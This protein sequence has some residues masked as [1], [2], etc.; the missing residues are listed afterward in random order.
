MKKKMTNNP[1][2]RD[3]YCRVCNA[4][5]KT[6]PL[7]YTQYRKYCSEECQK[8]WN[9]QYN[10]NRSKE[11]SEKTKLLNSASKPMILKEPEMCVEEL[12]NT[13]ISINLIS[14]NTDAKGIF[15]IRT[16]IM[17]KIKRLGIPHQILPSFKMV[18]VFKDGMEVLEQRKY[19][20]MHITPLNFFKLVE[21]HRNL[22]FETKKYTNLQSYKNIIENFKIFIDYVNNLNTIEGK[23]TK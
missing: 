5:L 11:V 23:K 13:L 2:V 8:E 14:F 17:Q 9:Y 21:Y 16:G 22:Y 12:K 4:P 20:T 6:K 18:K 19:N 3:D 15:S 1:F 7:R 10:K